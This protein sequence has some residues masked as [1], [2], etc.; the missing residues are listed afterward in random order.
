MGKKENRQ[1]RK[2]KQGYRKIPVKKHVYKESIK[3]YVMGST[4]DT[5]NLGLQAEVSRKPV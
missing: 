1:E 4:H 3:L 2:T 5:I